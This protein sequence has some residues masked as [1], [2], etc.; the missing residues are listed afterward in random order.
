MLRH[1]DPERCNERHTT[2]YVEID[3]LEMMI[4]R[5]KLP[6]EYQAQIDAIIAKRLAIIK[7]M[8]GPGFPYL[9]RSR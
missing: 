4:K 1:E 8:V 3:R 5:L 2:A 9:P 6:D 7:A